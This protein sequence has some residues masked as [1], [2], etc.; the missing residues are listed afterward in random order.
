MQRDSVN[1]KRATKIFPKYM[2]KVL[3]NLKQ[4]KM[5]LQI[6]TK[7]KTQKLNY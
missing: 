1:T 3:C 5:L 4:S 2:S 6:L 7:T